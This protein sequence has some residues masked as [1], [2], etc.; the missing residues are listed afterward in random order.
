M[1]YNW[2]S[3]IITLQDKIDELSGKI[4]DG[5]VIDFSEKRI[6]TTTTPVKGA[7]SPGK[8]G[9]VAFIIQG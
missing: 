6:F 7:T 9:S 4:Q 1:A 8:Q 2:D 5:I 3:N